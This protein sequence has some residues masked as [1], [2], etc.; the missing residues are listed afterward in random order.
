MPSEVVAEEAG[1]R[2]KCKVDSY[3]PLINTKIF[4]ERR[5]SYELVSLG[6]D[7]ETQNQIWSSS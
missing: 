2:I 5:W 6:L 3:E 4:R 7:F 1:L